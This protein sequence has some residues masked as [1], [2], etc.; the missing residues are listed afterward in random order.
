M[1]RPCVAAATAAEIDDSP[2]GEVIRRSR[3][4]SELFALW[5]RTWPRT[6]ARAR[7]LA[8]KHG[9]RP[10]SCSSPASFPEHRRRGAPSPLAAPP[11]SGE[12]AASRL[13]RRSYKLR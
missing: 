1:K 8:G 5:A 11:P 10:A 13:Y 2:D 4:E 12:R 6:S 9:S 7:S 3:S